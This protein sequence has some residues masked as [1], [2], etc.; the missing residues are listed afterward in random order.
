M[1]GWKGLK[2]G[3]CQY[4]G[5]DSQSSSHWWWWYIR[6]SGPELKVVFVVVVLVVVVFVGHRIGVDVLNRVG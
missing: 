1:R 5:W 6:L 3:A 2:G 4:G